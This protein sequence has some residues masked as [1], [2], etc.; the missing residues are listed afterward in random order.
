MLSWNETYSVLV[1]KMD[2]HHKHLLHVM[3][4]LSEDIR[5]RMP[6]E[7]I[8]RHFDSLL[9]YAYKHFD[10]EEGIMELYGYPE[11]N[12]HK[13]QHRF[14]LREVRDLQT[15]YKWGDPT[16][17]ISLVNHLGNWFIEHI[18]GVD[19]KYGQYFSEKRISLQLTVIEEY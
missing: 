12:S 16:V 5:K 17:F 15:K 6:R 9:D 10:A 3:N 11:L 1:P 13:V 4:G 8:G 14:F 18:R 7:E 2:N 19:K